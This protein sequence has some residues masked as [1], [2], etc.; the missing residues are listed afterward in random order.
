MHFGRQGLLLKCCINKVD[1]TLFRAAVPPQG[2]IMKPRPEINIHHKSI[3]AGAKKR[4]LMRTVVRFQ[5][6]DSTTDARPELC[7]WT[8]HK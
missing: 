4:N 1:L 5:R 6:Y 3:K 8:E 7:F 2:V